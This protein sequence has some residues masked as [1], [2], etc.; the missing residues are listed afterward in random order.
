MPEGR[1]TRLKMLDINTLLL[2]SRLKSGESSEPKHLRKA[3]FLPEEPV[4]PTY[5]TLL[6]NVSNILWN[7]A[8]HI[9]EV[10]ML[11]FS[12]ADRDIYQDVFRQLSK[13]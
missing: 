12:L 3:H 8:D 11:L 2:G 9:H 7:D 10:E 13:S 5:L 4:Y 6:R 1:N